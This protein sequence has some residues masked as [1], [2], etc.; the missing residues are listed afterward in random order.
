MLDRRS[1]SLL[2]ILNRECCE[3]G[4]K[5]FSLSDLALMMPDHFAVGEEEVKDCILAL[6]ER[7]FISLK[8]HDDKEV[9]VKP[10]PKGRLVFENR[11]DEEVEKNRFAK[12]YLFYSII[13]S[14]IGGA[15]SV[16]LSI[17]TLII[18]GVVGGA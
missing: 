14:V 11:I 2:D 16:F 10:L 6:S 5:I 1:L 13:G 12:K 3:S 15:I 9:L 7:E 8:Y 4:Y 17:F 18:T